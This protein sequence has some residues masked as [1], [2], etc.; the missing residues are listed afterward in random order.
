[1]RHRTAALALL[2]AGAAAAPASAQGLP[3]GL[4]AVV[5]DSV[6]HPLREQVDEEL[7]ARLDEIVRRNPRQRALIASRKMAVG[8]VDMTQPEAPR[9]ARVNGAVM[10]YAASLPKIAILLAATQA[11]EDG[12][13]AESPANLRDLGLMIRK[14]SNSAATRM[15]EASGGM[16]AVEK[17]LRDPRYELYDPEAGGGLWVG[18][19]YAKGGESHRDPMKGLSH[20]ASVTQ[21]CRFYYLMATGRLVSPERSGQ[22]LEIMSDP[23]VHHKFVH[24][25][26]DVAPEAKLFRKSGTWRQWHADSV[27]VWGPKWRRYILVGLIE[28]AG[29]GLIM[30]NLV[31]Q[32]E[33]ALGH[34]VATRP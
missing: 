20:A 17:V 27:L 22:M 21:V 33:E 5:A 3:P 8:L 24:T 26:E 1:M 34:P 6:W 30:E 2:M 28:D 18:R 12:R 7:Q 19:P 15:L 4:P 16:L 14:S 32:A 13:L 31:G 29:G 11:L 10:M 9:F 23:G 25:L